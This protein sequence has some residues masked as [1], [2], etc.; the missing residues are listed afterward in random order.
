MNDPVAEFLAKGGK[1]TKVPA[2]VAAYDVNDIYAAARHGGRAVS[3]AKREAYHDVR[4]EMCSRAD[5][6]R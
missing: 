3:I 5:R 2:G 1:I 6:F 4:A